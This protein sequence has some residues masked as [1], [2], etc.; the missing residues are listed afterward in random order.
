VERLDYWAGARATGDVPESPPAESNGDDHELEELK[1][2][3][4]RMIYTL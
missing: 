3:F 2:A 1:V 4:R